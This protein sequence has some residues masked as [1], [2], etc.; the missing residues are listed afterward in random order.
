M[1]SAQSYRHNHYV[2]EWYQRRFMLPGQHKYHY[3]DLHPE[4]RVQNGHRY[5][6][7]ALHEWGPGKCFAQDDLYTT[8]W[9]TITNTEIEQFFFGRIDGEGLN[10]VDYF[11]K[12]QHPGADEPALLNLMNYMTVQKLRTPKGLGWLASVGG[13]TGSNETLLRG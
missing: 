5:T 13:S 12:F 11:A 10:A 4:Q 2:P 6:Q 8:R 9:R 1:S 7:R 3:L